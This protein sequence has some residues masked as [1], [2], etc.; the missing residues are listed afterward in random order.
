LNKSSWSLDDVLSGG[1][2][3]LGYNVSFIAASTNA[4]VT[5][6]IEVYVPNYVW[7]VF[8]AISATLL[9]LMGLIGLCLRFATMAPNFFDPVMG[10]TYGNKYMSSA[11]RQSPLDAEERFKVLADE[12][13]RLGYVDTNDEIAKVVFGDE[14]YVRPLNKK[15]RYY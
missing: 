8:L 4:T 1:V 6:H 15:M 5:R 7:V 2:P 12:R 14:A 11:S 3:E 9:F 13:I 10:L